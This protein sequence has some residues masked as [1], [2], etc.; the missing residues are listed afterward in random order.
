MQDMSK[1]SG[2]LDLLI[3][4]KCSTDT[5]DLAALSIIQELVDQVNVHLVDEF[6]NSAVNDRIQP[7]IIRSPA[8]LQVVN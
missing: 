3:I 4:S 7:E 1:A 5:G 6:R 8:V 2:L